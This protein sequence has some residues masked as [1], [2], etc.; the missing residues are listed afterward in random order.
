MSAR[1]DVLS[2]SEYKPVFCVFCSR[3]SCGGRTKPD[4]NYVFSPGCDVTC[5]Q[6][7]DTSSNPPVTNFVM[8]MRRNLVSLPSMNLQN[9][10]RE[11]DEPRL[12]VDREKP[13]ILELTSLSPSPKSKSNR[14]GKVE[15]GLW[16]VSKI[17]WATHHGLGMT[18]GFT[19]WTIHYHSVIC[20]TRTHYRIGFW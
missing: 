20:V 8:R 17:S 7:G 14:K 9:I 11:E 6:H 3:R 19:S 12:V 1:K 18:Q 5:H 2:A 15:F 4:Y 16:A 13:V 10:S